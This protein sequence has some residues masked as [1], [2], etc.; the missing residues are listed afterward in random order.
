MSP[1]WHHQLLALGLAEYIRICSNFYYLKSPFTSLYPIF[2]KKQEDSI[3]IFAGT[4]EIY[5]SAWVLHISSLCKITRE[6]TR[7]QENKDKQITA[8][9]VGEEIVHLVVE[10]G[11]FACTGWRNQVLINDGENVTANLG[12]L[13]LYLVPIILNTPDIFVIALALLFLF[14]GGHD[15]P[16][17]SPGTNDILVSNGEQVP[18]FHRKLHVKLCNFLHGLNHFCWDRETLS[19]ANKST[20][21]CSSCG[22]GQQYTIPRSNVSEPWKPHRAPTKISDHL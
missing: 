22:K 16:W 7:K 9:Q 4:K 1:H 21:S 10:H 20:R 2:Q 6:W 18:L 14:Y 3:M 8:M 13:L 12:Q 11:G 15:P 19:F 17:G 5:T